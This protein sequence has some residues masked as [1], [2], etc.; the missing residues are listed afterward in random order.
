MHQQ[1][2]VFQPF[3]RIIDS[4]SMD[5]L[6][7]QNIMTPKAWRRRM[8]NT[9]WYELGGCHQK[10][11]QKMACTTCQSGW[12]FG[13]IDTGNGE[14]TCKDEYNVTCRIALT[15]ISTDNYPYTDLQS[16]L[17]SSNLTDNF[18]LFCFTKI[19]FIVAGTSSSA[20]TACQL[21][22]VILAGC[23][24]GRIFILTSLN[25]SKLWLKNNTIRSNQK[26]CLPLA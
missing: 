9:L 4:S 25:M 22:A 24:C 26:P 5:L 15:M 7:L 8:S 10:Q 12:D 23:Y 1:N 3:Q 2:I 20:W 18:R 19:Q 13:I 16:L 11:P 14:V 17:V 21:L 6:D